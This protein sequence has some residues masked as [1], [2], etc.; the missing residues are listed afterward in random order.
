MIDILH[1][2]LRLFQYWWIHLPNDQRF[3]EIYVMTKV[4]LEDMKIYIFSLFNR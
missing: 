1:S 2:R 4:I 3:E